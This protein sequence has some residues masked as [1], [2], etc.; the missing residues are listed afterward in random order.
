MNVNIKEREHGLLVS[1][2]CSAKAIG[3]ETHIILDSNSI[4]LYSYTTLICTKC[5]QPCTT[6]MEDREGN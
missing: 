4:P 5:N 2:C 1:L 6:V 3:R